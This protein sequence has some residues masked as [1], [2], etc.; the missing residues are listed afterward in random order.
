MKNK[1]DKIRIPA[2]LVLFITCL[3]DVVY[4]I[5]AESFPFYTSAMKPV[6][7]LLFL[8]TIRAN[9]KIGDLDVIVEA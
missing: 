9:L 5:I 4:S 1:K 3:I 6:V 8:N 2:M 7:V